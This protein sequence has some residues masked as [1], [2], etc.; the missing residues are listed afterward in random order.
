VN[1]DGEKVER[2]RCIVIGQSGLLLWFPDGDARMLS[3]MVEAEA[4]LFLLDHLD[5]KKREL[6]SGFD[7]LRC[8]QTLMTVLMDSSVKLQADS[9][10]M[11]DDESSNNWWY[12]F[13]ET[14]EARTRKRTPVHINDMRH[15]WGEVSELSGQ[16]S[17]IDFY[18]GDEDNMESPVGREERRALSA[19]FTRASSP[20]LLE[21]EKIRPNAPASVLRPPASAARWE[22]GREVREWS[23]RVGSGASASPSADPVFLEWMNETGLSG[24]SGLRRESLVILFRRKFRTTSLQMSSQASLV[25]LGIDA[26]QAKLLRD[27]LDQQSA[28]RS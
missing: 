22:A 28:A 24:A 20:I 21:W 15:A 11:C 4:F 10:S 16:A 7:S 17:E 14:S 6:G 2:A 12:Q 26:D 8:F 1:F 27:L 19:A 25:K 9:V 18:D 3:A 23:E 5:R 13:S